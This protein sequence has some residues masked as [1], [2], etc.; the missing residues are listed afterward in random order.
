MAL[1]RRSQRHDTFVLD[2]TAGY[3]DRVAAALLRRFR[4]DLRI[5]ITDSTWSPGATRSLLS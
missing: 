1:W 4:A 5:I 3:V 2:A